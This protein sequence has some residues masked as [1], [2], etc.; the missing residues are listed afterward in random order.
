MRSVTKFM[1][2]IAKLISTV[3]QKNYGVGLKKHEVG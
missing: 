3:E 1:R 2:P